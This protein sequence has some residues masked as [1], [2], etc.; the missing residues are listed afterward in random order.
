MPFLPTEDLIVR[1]EALIGRRKVVHLHPDTALRVVDALRA[2]IAHPN[3]DDI[4]RIICTRRC[5]SE[6]RCTICLGKAN[7]IDRMFHGEEFPGKPAPN[8][9]GGG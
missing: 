2:S 4:L 8:H 3:R 6:T 9:W 5:S 1:M 7:V